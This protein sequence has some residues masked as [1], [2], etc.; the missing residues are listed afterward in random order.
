MYVIPFNDAEGATSVAI[1]QIEASVNDAV[2]GPDDD[3]IND[4]DKPVIVFDNAT[5]T[6]PL[7][8][9]VPFT[10]LTDAVNCVPFTVIP[11]PCNVTKEAVVACDALSAYDELK[12]YELLTACDALNAH[13]AVPNKLPVIDPVNIFNVPDMA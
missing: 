10:C 9:S 4:D 11:N 8:G 5:D 3:T 6:L 13:D 12:A 1:I 2:T 7:T